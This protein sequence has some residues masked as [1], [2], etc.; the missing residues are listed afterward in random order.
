MEL[1]F[2]PSPFQDNVLQEFKCLRGFTHAIREK[3]LEEG[4]PNEALRI[5]HDNV[6]SANP[7]S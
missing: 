7:F 2:P 3:I 6:F 4:F 1:K 5:C